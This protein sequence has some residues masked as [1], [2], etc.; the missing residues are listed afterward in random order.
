MVVAKGNNCNDF[1]Q[2]GDSIQFSNKTRANSAAGNQNRYSGSTPQRY[3]SAPPTG[4][5]NN[6]AGGQNSQGY[7]P[8]LY[9]APPQSAPTPRPTP[10]PAPPAPD[11]GPVPQ[12]DEGGGNDPDPDAGSP[13]DF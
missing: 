6:S 11:P 10:Q 1:P 2:P 4:P 13:G 5:G 3:Y 9:D 8:R 7:D 12:P